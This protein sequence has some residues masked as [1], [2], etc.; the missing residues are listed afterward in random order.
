MPYNVSEPTYVYIYA[1]SSNGASAPLH[2]VYRAPSANANSV[3]LYGYGI[4]L[5]DTTAIDTLNGEQE[6]LTDDCKIFTLGGQQVNELQPGM[7]IVRMKNG[8][9]KKVLIK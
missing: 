2:R 3:I 1:T 6:A 8:T 4:K 9:V 5:D 7:N